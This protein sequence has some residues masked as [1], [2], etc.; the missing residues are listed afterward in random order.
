MLFR[1]AASPYFG[2]LGL[3]ILLSAI[4]IN[5]VGEVKEQGKIAL[6]QKAT[7]AGITLRLDDAQVIQYAD[8]QSFQASLSVLDQDGA[9]TGNI[10]S[11]LE[12]FSTSE[13][14]QAQVGILSNLTHDIYVVLDEADATPGAQ[15]VRITV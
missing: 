11:M 9:P 12:K 2:H 15:W 10:V 5:V 7:I 4:T 3:I 8:R 14:L 6:N 13:N 1:S